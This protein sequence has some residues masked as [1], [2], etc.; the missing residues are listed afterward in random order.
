MLTVFGAKSR[1]GCLRSFGGYREVLKRVFTRVDL[2]RPDSPARV[3]LEEPSQISYSHSMLTNDHNVE[4]EAFPHTLAMPL[5]GQVGETNV[6]SEL[7]A[8]NVLHV[9]RCLSGGLRVLRG[10]G[11]RGHVAAMGVARRD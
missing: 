4:V 6:S 10:H 7:S 8:H 9:R 11:L 5:V 1:D 2:P 3:C